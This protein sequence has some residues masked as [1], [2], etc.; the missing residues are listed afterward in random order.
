MPEPASVPDQLTSKLWV[1]WVAASAVMRLV[2]DVLSIV[3]RCTLV[4]I[5]AFTSKT[6]RA[7]LV[8]AVL[9]TRLAFGVTVNVT[10]ACP[11]GEVL[12]GGRN[13]AK[14]SSG[15]LPEDASS[16]LNVQVMRPLV[17]L[18]SAEILTSRLFS[19]LRSAK[20]TKDFSPAGGVNRRLP[21]EMRPKLKVVASTLER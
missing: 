10:L 14:G 1:G 6:T 16:E 19:G 18:K 17:G 11:S 3:F 5:G 15:G 12:L 4:S 20:P 2:G 8:T 21:N 9:V 7:V 13:P